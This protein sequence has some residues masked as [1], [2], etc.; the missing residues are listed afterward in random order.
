MI[1]AGHREDGYEFQ[2]GDPARAENWRRFGPSRGAVERGDDGADWQF[3]GGDPGDPGAWS[4]VEPSDPLA[5]EYAR[6][7]A[8]LDVARGLGPTAVAGLQRG[9][10]GVGQ[11]LGEFADAVARRVAQDPEYLNTYGSDLA[12]LALGRAIEAQPRRRRAPESHPGPSGFTRASGGIAESGRINLDAARPEGDLS[13]LQTGALNAAHSLGVMAPSLLAGSVGGTP[14]AL[15]AIGASTFGDAYS[16]ARAQGRTPAEAARFAAGQAAVEVGT[17]MLPTAALLKAGEPLWKRGLEYA[18]SE[19]P[20]ELLATTLQGGQETLEGLRQTPTGKD[21]TL[22]DFVEG[23]PGELR[24][25]VVSTLMTGGVTVPAAHALDRARAPS[26]LGPNPVPVIPESS[27]EQGQ[28]LIEAL[29]ALRAQGLPAYAGAGGAAPATTATPPVAVKRPFEAAPA[30]GLIEA[31]N[32]LQPEVAPEAQ[33]TAPETRAPISVPT[34]APQT[35]RAKAPAVVAASAPSEAIE[36][37]ALLKKTEVLQQRARAARARYAAESRIDPVKD[38]ILAAIAKLGGWNRAEA[39]AQGIDPAEFGRRGW[40]IKKVF[41]SRGDTAD[42]LAERLN[43]YGYPVTDENGNY[44]ANALLAAVDEALHGRSAKQTAQGTEAAFAAATEQSQEDEA[45]QPLLLD[46]DEYD[47]LQT[48]PEPVTASGVRSAPLQAALQRVLTGLTGAPQLQVVQSIADLPPAVAQA[49]QTKL[50]AQPAAGANVEGVWAGD[51]VWLVADNIANLD[52]AI[53]VFLHEV[54]GHGGVR[55]LFN[56]NPGDTASAARFNELLD[57]IVAAYRAGKFDQWFHGEQRHYLDLNIDAFGDAHE[58]AEEFLARLAESLTDQPDRTGLLDRARRILL[59]FLRSL[60]GAL[61]A[62]ARQMTRADIDEILRQAV[63]RVERGPA[64]APAQPRLAR[65]ASDRSTQDLLGGAGEQP[66]DAEV[67]VQIERE[68]PLFQLQ[69]QV[70]P[71]EGRQTDAFKTRLSRAPSDRFKTIVDRML[72]EQGGA[73]DAALFN[74]DVGPIDLIYGEPGSRAKSYAD[75]YGLSHILAKHPEIEPYALEDIVASAHKAREKGNTIELETP[76]HLAIIK[77][78][79]RGTPRRWLLTAFETNPARA[80]ERIGGND[81]TVPEPPSDQVAESADRITDPRLSRG[82]QRQTGMDGKVRHEFVEYWI[83][84]AYLTVVFAAFTQYQRLVLAAHDITYTN[85]GVAVI[86][87]L[88]LG[89]V[90]MIGRLFQLGRGLESKPLIYPTLYKTVV[91][92]V[93]V[94]AFKVIEHV[95]RVLWS[96]DGLAGVLTG[97]PDQTLAVVLANSLVIVVAFVPFFAFKELVRVL[98]AKETWALFFRKPAEPQIDAHGRG[99]RPGR[100]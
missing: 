97:I 31:L 72:R 65:D 2:G 98:G 44:T 40:R 56:L 76:D 4:R 84:V 20:G 69:G 42:G 83:N 87:A 34:P 43:Q 81:P 37:A 7:V 71:R 6:P 70:Q 94:G 60:P 86:E 96:G 45:A 14:A 53:R 35:A 23:L 13:M 5:S 30:A 63:H 16:E 33:Q 50:A 9:M 58:A 46:D 66:A 3:Q 95:V 18:A 75:G 89:K 12:E 49:V 100:L 51:R 22:S 90:I 61:G 55:S 80:V 68:R 73:A 67:R 38:G 36:D 99:E 8:S 27:Q 15:S 82:P 1:Q 57:D 91:F 47:G 88:I 39:E 54:V 74:I 29:R 64:A 10:G 62:R 32:T 85:Y 59:K 28:G 92:T 17:E 11:A 78:D 24:D 25:T 79:W 93:F 41:T 26:A 48:P 21:A 77:L 52:R 19:I